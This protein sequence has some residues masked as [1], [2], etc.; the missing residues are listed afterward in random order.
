MAAPVLP[1]PITV[2]GGP[3]PPPAVASIGVG[4]GLLSNV[5]VH[6]SIPGDSARVWQRKRVAETQMHTLTQAQIDD[7]ATLHTEFLAEAG[8]VA[9][10]ATLAPAI[11]AQVAAQLPAALPPGLIGLPAL[12]AANGA[13]AAANGVAL[14]ALAAQVAIGNARTE[15]TEARFR[16]AGAITRSM[17]GPAPPAEALVWPP[18]IP[19]GGGAP[20]PAPAGFPADTAAFSGAPHAVIEPIRAFYQVGAGAMPLQ[21]KKEAIRRHIAA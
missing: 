11:G 6:P 9:A 20:I 7:E 19:P 5:Q 2:P 16:N 12:V 21:A 15:I 10:H 8:R 18:Y 3:A 17:Q 14:A 13:A 4:S 1:T